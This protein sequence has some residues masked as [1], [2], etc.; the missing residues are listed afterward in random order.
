MGRFHQ[1]RLVAWIKPVKSEK[2]AGD[3]L[4]GR[5]AVNLR[6]AKVRAGANNS[7]RKLP[8]PE[9]PLQA[10]FSCA[11]WEFSPQI[12]KGRGGRVWG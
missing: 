10:I 1:N 8:F 9:T 4:I 11:F 2:G 7:C 5:T 3:P 12:R 6:E